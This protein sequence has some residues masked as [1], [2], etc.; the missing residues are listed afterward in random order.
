MTDDFHFDTEII[1]KLHHQRKTDHGSADPD[2]L[3][4]RT[5]PRGRP[6]IRQGRGAGRVALPADLP[7]RAARA[8]SSPS[9]SYTIR[10]STRARSSHDY[11]RRFTGAN[12]RRAG[13]RLRRGLLCRANWRATATASAAST[14]C[15]RPASATPWSEYV[16]MDLNAPAGYAA[17]QTG[18]PAVRPRAAAGRA[19]ASAASRG[20]AGRRQERACARMASWWCPCPT[21]PT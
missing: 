7:Q 8:R 11:A 21:W 17:G 20:P 19:G 14:C 9:T 2:L 13:H 12:Q 16:S 3:R 6:E 5:V 10:S 4:H 15:P 1:I 18:G